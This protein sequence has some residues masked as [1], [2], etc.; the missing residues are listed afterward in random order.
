VFKTYHVVVARSGRAVGALAG[1]NH[2]I[3]RS[4]GRR[5]GAPRGAG[6]RGAPGGVGNP[7]A[8]ARE[9][10]TVSG[11]TSHVVHVAGYGGA[12]VHTGWSRTPRRW[13]MRRRIHARSRSRHGLVAAPWCFPIAAG[14]REGQRPCRRVPLLLAWTCGHPPQLIQDPPTPI[15]VSK[16]VL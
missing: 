1:S 6:H 3:T 10:G 15:V 16:L 2:H 14:A 8:E 9:V 11:G 4:G 7:V 5:G 12:G 13:S